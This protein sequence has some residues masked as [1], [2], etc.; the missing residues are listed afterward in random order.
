MDKKVFDSTI[1]GLTGFLAL[2]SELPPIA[3][4]DPKCQI[5]A[6]ILNR[7][8]RIKRDFSSELPD[9]NLTKLETK[10]GKKSVKISKTF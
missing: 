1:T 7:A 3:V 8:L 2:Q 5:P 6:L 4:H 10:M 9:K